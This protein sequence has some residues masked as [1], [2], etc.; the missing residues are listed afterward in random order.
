MAIAGWLKNGGLMKDFLKKWVIN[1]WQYKI[2]AFIVAFI[3]WFYVAS[4]QNLNINLSVP[5]EF[6]NYPSDM[7]VKNKIKTSADLTVEGRRDIVT[8]MDKKAVKVVL[9]LK[10]SKA[11]GND[12]AISASQIK[13]VPRGLLI[14]SISPAAMVIDFELLVN[15]EQPKNGDKKQLNG[16]QQ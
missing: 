12:F 7:Q 2:A 1:R 8:K 3:L 5:I 13:G 10:K 9:D 4:E 15:A 14:R 6:V 11:G 16:K